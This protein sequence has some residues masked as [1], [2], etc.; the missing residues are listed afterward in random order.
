[1]SLSALE[2][3]YARAERDWL[4]PRDEPECDD[5]N[6]LVECERRV[7]TATAPDED[8]ARELGWTIVHTE[9][10]DMEMCPACV[11]A[12]VA[13]GHAAMCA[14]E[15]IGADEESDEAVASV[16]AHEIA[17]AALERAQRL[18]GHRHSSLMQER[19]EAGV[20]TG[21]W[22]ARIEGER[23]TAESAHREACVAVGRVV[24]MMSG[25]LSGEAGVL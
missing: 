14:G 22:I 1:M 16:A 17:R 18:G 25:S 10:H 5:L 20:E 12:M 21:C 4:T 3:S 23:M 2:A 8:T 11:A 9:D 24:G 13:E 15:Y 19:D 6:E 7:C